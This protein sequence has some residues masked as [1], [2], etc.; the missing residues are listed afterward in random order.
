MMRR[1]APF[2]YL[3]KRILSELGSHGE[4][5][6]ESYWLNTEHGRVAPPDIAARDQFGFS[7]ATGAGITAVI[8]AIGVDSLGM[9]AGAAYA[10]DMSWSS[11]AF[12]QSEYVILEGRSEVHIF[13]ARDGSSKD[14]QTIGFSTS[15]LSAKGVD[16]EAF[17]IC[18]ALPLK[19]RCCSCGDYELT[20]GELFFAEGET[21]AFFTIP[22]MDDLC[23]E[24][25]IEY[26][27]LQ[28]HIPGGGPIHGEHYRAHVR[29]DDNDW[30]DKSKC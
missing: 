2:T 7:L 25:K 8:G 28:L 15:D 13:V 1:R 22:I 17:E 18:R 29:I 16:S 9:D 19:E 21:L 4:V 3:Y 27:Q 6:K 14:N 26:L 23:Y 12:V 24:T 20:S 30:I 10:M 11:I 5:I